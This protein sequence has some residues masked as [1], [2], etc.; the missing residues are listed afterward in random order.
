VL[1]RVTWRRLAA[2]G[3]PRV[4]QET[5]GSPSST[6][7]ASPRITGDNLPRG[8]KSQNRP[9]YIVAGPLPVDFRYTLTSIQR[10]DQLSRRPS[11]T[12]ETTDRSRANRSHWPPSLE[13]TH[14]GPPTQ[15]AGTV[16]SKNL[17][18]IVALRNVGRAGAGYYGQSAWIEC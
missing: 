5:H 3:V 7:C 9:G 12:P 14:S 13:S 10:V 15:E 11:R 18:V 1:R 2:A 17:I 8:W 6:L 4:C 16:D